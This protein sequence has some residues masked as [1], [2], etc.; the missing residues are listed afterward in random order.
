MSRRPP[1][2]PHSAGEEYYHDSA[3]HIPESYSRGG[4]PSS[5]S[6]AP[7]ISA[8]HSLRD[9]PRSRSPDRMQDIHRAQRE[10]LDEVS[11]VY[12][13]QEHAPQYYQGPAAG[14]G[15]FAEPPPQSYNAAP[16][17][18]PESASSSAKR[19]KKRRGSHELDAE[20]DLNA[21]AAVDKDTGRTSKKARTAEGVNTN[22]GGRTLSCKECRRSVF[23]L[24]LFIHAAD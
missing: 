18:P 7:S 14:V 15:R 20:E 4:Y 12:Y 13:A 11:P 2:M 23:S 21:S 8:P 10:R 22:G 17:G 6:A 19:A 9:R 1:V 24:F 16:L 3:R 5:S